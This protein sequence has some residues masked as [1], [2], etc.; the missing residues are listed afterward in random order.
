[1]TA[2]ALLAGQDLTVGKLLIAKPELAD[3]NFAESVVLIVHYEVDKGAIGLILNRRTK[4]PISKVL[5]Q[6]KGAKEDPVFEGGPVETASAQ[7]LLRTREKPE[8]ATRVLPG[9]YASGSKEVIEK[10]VASGASPS[11]FRLYAGYA[12]WSPG[13]LEKEIEIGGWSVLRATTDIVFDEK[14]DSLWQ[15]LQHNTETRIASRGGTDDRFLSSVSSYYCP[16]VGVAACPSRFCR[17]G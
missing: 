4:I 12:G 2:M 6:I 7:A 9:V 14:P 15:R 17:R 1:V 5:P 10:F 11:E 13:Q 8:E 3:P 16:S